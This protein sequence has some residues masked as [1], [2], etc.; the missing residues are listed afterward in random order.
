MAE[1]W[2]R[3]AKYSLD[4]ADKRAAEARAAE[5]EH[6]RKLLTSESASRYVDQS[7]IN[8]EAYRMRFR[9]ITDA[10]KVDDAVCHNSRKILKHRSG[11]SYEDLILIDADTGAVIHELN[12][13]V[14]R[15]GVAYDEA[16]QAAIQKAHERGRRIVAIHNHPDNMPP[17][18]DDGVSL[19]THGY[20]FGIVV[21]HD[22]TVYEYTAPYREFTREECEQI[23]SDIAYQIKTGA[24]I[25]DVWYNMLEAYGMTIRRR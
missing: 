4:P 2:G 9:G 18:L 25:E 24:K 8:S 12:T 23:H 6:E 20:D 7:Y 3:R 17:S 19:L 22:G 10:P 16:V 14:V 1:R 13:S 5:W 15:G 11:S 21:T